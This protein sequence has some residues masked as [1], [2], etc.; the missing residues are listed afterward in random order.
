M[1]PMDEQEIDL[2]ALDAANEEGGPPGSP[3]AKLMKAIAP[4]NATQPDAK[5]PPVS[6]TLPPS[7]L[8]YLINRHSH[9]LRGTLHFA[10]CGTFSLGHLATTQCQRQLVHR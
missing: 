1:V 5:W 7:S 2:S 6:A 9:P 3:Q 4:P 10:D 8:S